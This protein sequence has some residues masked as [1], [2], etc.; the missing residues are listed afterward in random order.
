LY[1]ASGPKNTPNLFLV[2][3][4]AGTREHFPDRLQSDRVVCAKGLKIRCPEIG[5]RDLRSTIIIGFEKGL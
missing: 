2:V 4:Q 5:D 1:F 3:G